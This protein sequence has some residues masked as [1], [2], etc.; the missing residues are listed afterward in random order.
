MTTLNKFTSGVAARHH[1]AKNLRPETVTIADYNEHCGHNF[2]LCGDIMLDD[3]PQRQTTLTVRIDP[4]NS[5]RWKRKTEHIYAIVRNGEIMKLGGTRA[6]M[7][8]RWGSYK[9][10]HC[11]PQRIKRT[12]QPYP[13]KMSVTNAHVYHTIEDSLLKGDIWQFWSWEL[14]EHFLT[15]QMPTG[16][17]IQIATQTFHAYES[18]S[19]NEF[20]DIAGHIPQ[21]CDNSDPNY[22]VE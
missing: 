15:V 7:K 17:S 21:L 6:G 4:P 10:G 12:G 16:V 20:R 3:A 8:E 14:P 13:G 5:A 18:W 22:R 19:I 11:V 9:C 1:W 2:Q